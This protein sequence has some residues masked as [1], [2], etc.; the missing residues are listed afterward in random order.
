LTVDRHKVLRGLGAAAMSLLLAAVL[1]LAGCSNSN[2]GVTGS[3]GV[4]IGVALAT[5]DD[6][7]QLLVGESLVITAS[8][9]NDN[10]GEGV[11][12][13]LSEEALPV[14]AGTAYTAGELIDATPTSVVFVAPTT[15]FAGET[16][17]TI[18][19][20]SKVNSLYYSSVTIVTLGT[21]FFNPTTLF[22]ANENVA[23]STSLT[24]SG[25]TAPFTWVLASGSAAL[26]AG[27]ILEGSTTGLDSIS[28]VPTVTGTFPV[29]V[30]VTDDT[31]AV[32]TQTFTITI[33]PQE[34]CV[35]TPGSYTLLAQG[36][37]GGGGMTHVATITLDAAGNITGEQDYKDGHRTTVGE[38]LT[39]TSNCINRETNSGQITLESATGAFLYNVSVTPPDVNNLSQ[40]ARIQLIG[41]GSDSAGGLLQRVDTTAITA[42]PPTGNFAF[43]L[44]G[45]QKQEPV[46]VHFASAGRF[47]TDT[48]GAMTAGLIDSNNTPVLSQA[49]LGGT[50]SAPDANGRGTANFVIGGTSSAYVYYIINASKMYLM[51]VDP[52]VSGGINPRSSGYMTPQVGNVGGTSFDNTAF[53]SPA[54]L[55]LWGA[56]SGS[57]PITDQTLGLLSGSAPVAGTGTGTINGLLDITDRIVEYVQQ[58]FPAQPF[59][60]DANGRGTMT[61][62]NGNASYSLVFY[63]DG[64]SDGYLVSQN[65]GTSITNG[66]G[67]GGLLEAQYIPPSTGFPTT[68]NGYYVGGTQFAMA[69][70]PITLNPLASLDF[71]TLSSNFTNGLFYINQT[72]GVGLGTL[73]Q[74]GIGEQPASLYIVS[75][76]KFEILRFSTRAVDGNIDWLVQNVD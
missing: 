70:G 55:S 53:T 67:A 28:G 33:N 1:N 16:S 24:V 47:S 59:T 36:F 22:P 44:L 72:T 12:W 38:Q 21:M 49:A 60:V 13:T 57:E 19:G 11:V 64:A 27:L 43:G 58:A 7:T 65:T 41:S 25:G 8:V 2:R 51:N 30:Q 20:T 39:S 66:D 46:T 32:V 63:L 17:A 23:Y 69:P 40:S 35:L 75:P 76:T 68:F 71:G 45:V 5:S 9:T 31:A 61:L 42:S 52:Y 6:V 15:S 18:T 26:P 4:G 10:T 56:I 62:V 74:S 54:V 37:R 48:S 34:T 14:P 29:T 50:L 3:V 73:T